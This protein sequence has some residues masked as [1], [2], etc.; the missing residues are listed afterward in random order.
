MAVDLQLSNLFYLCHLFIVD[1]LTERQ[2]GNTFKRLFLNKLAVL[3][4]WPAPW[5]KKIAQLCSKVWTK[6]QLLHASPTPM[7]QEVKSRCMGCIRP[8]SACKM[9]FRVPREMERRLSFRHMRHLFQQ[10]RW[11]STVAFLE[12]EIGGVTQYSVLRC[13]ERVKN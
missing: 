5:H 4:V 3:L 10:Q 2:C 7:P 9:V 12:K 1:R 6:R 8:A 13:W 11:G